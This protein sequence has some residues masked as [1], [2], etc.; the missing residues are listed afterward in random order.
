[1]LM[2]NK[3]TKQNKNTDDTA[4]HCIKETFYDLKL[5]VGF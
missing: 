2:K 5:N 1:M 3:K 4:K